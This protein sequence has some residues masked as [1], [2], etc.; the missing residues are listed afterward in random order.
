[1]GSV[2]MI[3]SL[4]A[5]TLVGILISPGVKWDVLLKRI[6]GSIIFLIAFKIGHRGSSFESL[7]VL[8]TYSERALLSILVICQPITVIDFFAAGEKEN[9]K[10]YPPI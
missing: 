6:L 5:I 8:F 10:N 7:G 3:S 2:E 4:I 1:M 9:L